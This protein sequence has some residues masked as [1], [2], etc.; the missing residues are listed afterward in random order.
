MD[1]LHSYQVNFIGIYVANC[2]ESANSSLGECYMINNPLTITN[3]GNPLGS[4]MER[5]IVLMLRRI[6]MVA[7]LA[8][9]RNF[10]G[11]GVKPPQKQ[12]TC[13]T[14]EPRQTDVYSESED[15]M[16]PEGKFGISA[17]APHVKDW[18]PTF[19]PIVDPHPEIGIDTVALSNK[20][21]N[22]LNCI[23]TMGLRHLTTTIGSAN[24]DMMNEFYTNLELGFDIEKEYVVQV[25]GSELKFSYEI[26]NA[27]M[28]FYEKSPARLDD[29]SLRV[30]CARIRHK[31]C[32]PISIAT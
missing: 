27:L 23:T 6:F 19:K 2:Y 20:F 3:L 17:V 21:L 7:F 5:M 32:G 13:P 10:H 12:E 22:V 18:Y 25:R 9:L 28:D 15:T 16:F 8:E 30:D 31:L 29:W 11:I 4:K 1:E 26:I 14:L 24:I